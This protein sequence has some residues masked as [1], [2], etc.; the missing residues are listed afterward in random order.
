MLKWDRSAYDGLHI[1][2]G[3]RKAWKRQRFYTVS[4]PHLQGIEDMGQGG[5]KTLLLFPY[6]I[7]YMKIPRP[8]LIVMTQYFHKG[9][10]VCS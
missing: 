3:K 6:K 1:T 4:Q 2:Q 8:N 7:Q 9:D 10:E 5:K